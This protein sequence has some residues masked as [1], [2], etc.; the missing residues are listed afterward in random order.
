VAFAPFPQRYPEK[1]QGFSWECDSPRRRINIDR[2]R[3]RA[4]TRGRRL[5]FFINLEILSDFSTVFLGQG[6]KNPAFLVAN[7][8]ILK[9]TWRFMCILWYNFTFQSMINAVIFLTKKRCLDI[10]IQIFRVLA[11]FSRNPPDP[12]SIRY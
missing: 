1:E 2:G 11:G 9:E 6:V 4:K 8:H 3:H 5:D 12:S 10:Y 7:H